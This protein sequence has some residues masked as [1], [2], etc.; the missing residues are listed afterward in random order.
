MI[1]G[2]GVSGVQRGRSSMATSRF[3]LVFVRS[4]KTNGKY[5]NMLSLSSS[6]LHRACATGEGVEADKFMT[7]DLPRESSS[8]LGTAIQPTLNGRVLK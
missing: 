8:S 6:F 7:N 2:H 4:A 3:S 1:V 5:L